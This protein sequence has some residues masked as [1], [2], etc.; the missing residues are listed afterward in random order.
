MGGFDPDP[1]CA[2]RIAEDPEVPEPTGGSERAKGLSQALVHFVTARASLF[3]DQRMSDLPVRAKY[4]LVSTVLEHKLW[5]ILRDRLKSCLF[6]VV[7]VEAWSRDL[8]Q[9]LSILVCQFTTLVHAL[10]RMIF[11]V[12]RPSDC[13]RG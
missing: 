9:L 4:K 6:E 2:P 12:I 8:K 11:H 1:P 13:F 10:F 5:T 3:A 7:V